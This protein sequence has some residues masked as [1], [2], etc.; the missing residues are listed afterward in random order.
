MLIIKD[1]ID[2]GFDAIHPIEP[3]CMSL[4]EVKEKYGDKVCIMGNVDCAY[5]LVF[6][7]IIDVER[8][9]KR[10]IAKRLCIVDDL[11]SLS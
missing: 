9:V 7:S 4:K 5:T 3:P 1:F 10:C 6:G 11:L 2:A 8:D